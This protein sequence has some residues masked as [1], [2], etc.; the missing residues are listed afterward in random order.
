MKLGDNDTRETTPN[1]VNRLCAVITCTTCDPRGQ[2]LNYSKVKNRQNS[3]KI[4]ISWTSCPIKSSRSL[5]REEAKL[6]YN[7]MAGQR[8]CCFCARNQND[9][10][11]GGGGNISIFMNCKIN[12]EMYFLGILESI[13]SISETP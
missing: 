5:G 7:H 1:N 4:T 11:C 2:H 10:L 3:G 6:Y 12:I 8:M 9:T 13:L